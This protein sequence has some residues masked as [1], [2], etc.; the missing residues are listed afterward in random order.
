M[1]SPE[2]PFSS[3]IS[4]VPF[5]KQTS[6]SGKIT[7]RDVNS[8]KVPSVDLG[9][10]LGATVEG[11][12]VRFCRMQYYVNPF[13]WAELK[14]ASKPSGSAYVVSAYLASLVN[15]VPVLA[16]SVSIGSPGIFVSFDNLCY[17]KRLREEDGCANQEDLDRAIQRGDDVRKVKPHWAKRFAKDLGGE[18]ISVFSKFSHSSL[19][20]NEWFYES[21]ACAVSNETR[22]RSFFDCSVS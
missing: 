3:L 18:V 6:N 14:D 22:G 4:N 11:C 15:G 10:Y 16:R 7:I 20:R 1:S 21:E 9:T 8:F 2:T 13:D 17:T 19:G 5:L 12:T